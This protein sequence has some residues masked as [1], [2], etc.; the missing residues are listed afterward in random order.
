M[1]LKDAHLHWSL[2]GAGNHPSFRIG[3]KGTPE[4]RAFGEAHTFDGGASF[5]KWRQASDADRMRMLLHWLRVAAVDQG[6]LF[7]MI[8]RELHKID[9]LEM[10]P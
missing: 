1:K 4:D 7:E 5:S 8:D 10:L 3:Q 6:I 2:P 9:D